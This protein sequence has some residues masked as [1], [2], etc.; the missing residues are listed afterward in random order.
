MKRIIATTLA[1]IMGLTTTYAQ[2][3]SDYI[4]QRSNARGMLFN[5]DLMTIADMCNLSQSSFTYGTAR[6]AALSGAMA[7]LGGDAS[8]SLIN[9]AGLG[10]YLT[11][12]FSLSPMYISSKTSVDG[13]TMSGDN[14]TNKLA[15]SNMSMVFKVYESGNTKLTALNFGVS[16][17]RTADFNQAYSVK[18]TGSSSSVANLFSRQ[19]TE[20]QTP[21]SSLFGSN[22]PDWSYMPSNMWGAALGYKTGL[23]F[24]TYGDIPSDYY[25]TDADGSASQNHRDPVTQSDEIAW[26]STWI[27]SGST[28]DQTMTYVSSGSAG[29]YGF[30]MGGN[31]NNKLYFGA[32]LGISTINQRIDIYYN[33]VYNNSSTFESSNK[34]NYSNYNQAIII[35][36]TGVNFKMGVTYRLDGLRLAVAYHTPTS[37]SISR[38][39]Q[40]SVN[41]N[42][43][44]YGSDGQ[45]TT[46]NI[47]ADSPVI[48]DYGSESWSM[49][50]PSKLILGGSYIF[51]MCALVS[52]DYQVDYYNNIKMKGTPTGVSTQLYSG[53]SDILNNVKSYRMGAEYKV[54]PL[55]TIRGGYS[56][57]SDMVNDSAAASTALWDIPVDNSTSSFSA[58]VGFL[59]SMNSYFDITYVRQTTT[60]TEYAMF[61][62]EG[63]LNANAPSAVSAQSVRLSNK[64]RESWITATLRFNI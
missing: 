41:G 2:D 52:F 1:L 51:N 22:N 35:N 30:S 48:E 46:S 9:P 32:T 15:F 56:F 64:F 61:W 6:S 59:I 33:E 31:L 16:Y 21:L 26:N 37:Y 54:T 38:Q 4:T 43:T 17:N 34:L 11:N 12:E 19:L 50:S 28:V 40:T 58:G 3:V 8:S 45:T 62:G 13:G 63:T 27:D 39:Y 24:Q 47:M 14:N 44:Y 57:T 18:S 23:T 60:Q 5:R 55:F 36:G 25:D 53:I 20:S 29:E 42:S 49:N 7:S 10:M